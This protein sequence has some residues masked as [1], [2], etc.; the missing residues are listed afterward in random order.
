[1]EK[2]LEQKSLVCEGLNLVKKTSIL[3]ESM[4][5]I[6]K[7]FRTLRGRNLK[8]FTPKHIIGKLSRAEKQTLKSSMK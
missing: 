2:L 1:M 6:F 7:K 5:Y 4:I 3:D 8:I